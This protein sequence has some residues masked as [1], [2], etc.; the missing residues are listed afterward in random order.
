MPP[1]P[2]PLNETLVES[3]GGD[4]HEFHVEKFFQLANHVCDYIMKIVQLHTSAE[5]SAVIFVFFLDGLDTGVLISGSL[6][7]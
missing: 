5:S 7:P 1:P 3:D 4:T 6:L 2:P